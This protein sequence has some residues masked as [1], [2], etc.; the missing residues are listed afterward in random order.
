LGKERK[1][2]KADPTTKEK[3]KNRE[4]WQSFFSAT[5]LT[6]PWFFAQE[7]RKGGRQKHFVQK[8]EKVPST[9]NFCEPQSS[10]AYKKKGEK[11][12]GS[13]A[14]AYEVAEKRR[15]A[16]VTAGT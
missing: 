6:F 10:P 7:K 5:F 16:L 14:L 12:E 15:E 1:V 2:N 4:A 8:G 3:G 9:T 13:G 11:K